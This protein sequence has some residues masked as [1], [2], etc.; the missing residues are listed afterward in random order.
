MTHFIDLSN[1]AA[2]NTTRLVCLSCYASAESH[3]QK[4][5]TRAVLDLSGL[6]VLRAQ[7]Q[8]VGGQDPLNI[9]I[10]PPN[11]GQNF[12]HGGSVTLQIEMFFFVFFEK[13]IIS[14]FPFQ[15]YTKLNDLKFKTFLGSDSRSP[16]S[17]PLH[18]LFLGLCPRFG[19]RPQI[20]G[21]LSTRFGLIARFGLHPIRTPNF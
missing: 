5:S 11:F 4:K 8:G 15:L 1:S 13:S 20:S 9:F 2:A 19:L 6:G 10:D 14:R 12:P 17:R 3:K 21:A 16:L 18:L 7:P